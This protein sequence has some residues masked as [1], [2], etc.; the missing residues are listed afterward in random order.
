MARPRTS[1]HVM[2]LRQRSRSLLLFLE[3]V[4]HRSSYIPIAHNYRVEG[5]CI[6]CNILFIYKLLHMILIEYIFFIAGTEA[7]EKLTN[8]TV[9]RYIVKDV[10]QL[11][12]NFQTSSLEAFHSLI[13][14]F[15]PKHTGFSF[16]GML[17]RYWYINKL[18]EKQIDH[19]DT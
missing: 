11:S 3:N 7:Y 17:C 1:L 5:I 8:L 15:A 18:A 12:P 9:N 4:C 19:I 6:V 2:M 16:L 10:R 14:R 13:L